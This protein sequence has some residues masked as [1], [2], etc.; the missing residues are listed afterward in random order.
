VLSLLK[1]KPAFTLKFKQDAA[2]LVNEKD[3]RGVVKQTI[4]W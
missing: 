4:F 2:Q 3:Y 1:A